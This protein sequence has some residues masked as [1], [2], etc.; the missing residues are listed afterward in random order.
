M[1]SIVTK[2]MKYRLTDKMQ[3]HKVEIHYSGLELKSG[4]WRYTNPRQFFVTLGYQLT[5]LHRFCYKI[6]VNYTGQN[7]IIYMMNYV[8]I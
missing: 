2:L 8:E 6:T 1:L 4:V 7:Y 3:N 5:L